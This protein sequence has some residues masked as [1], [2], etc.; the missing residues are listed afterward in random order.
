MLM[1]WSKTQHSWASRAPIW[2]SRLGAQYS[3]AKFCHQK[4]DKHDINILQHV[5]KIG[6]AP[7][8]HSKLV[9]Y[10]RKSNQISQLEMKL[11]MHLGLLFWWQ[12]HRGSN[13]GCMVSKEKSKP[14]T[15]NRKY[16]HWQACG[17]WAMQD[18]VMLPQTHMYMS[19]LSTPYESNIFETDPQFFKWFLRLAK[20]CT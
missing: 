14:N 1:T 17:I 11:W 7:Q 6:R 19:L 12:E 15:L 4:P 8:G 5:Q 20:F 9:G 3:G 13:P 16:I 18:H 2:R 10:M